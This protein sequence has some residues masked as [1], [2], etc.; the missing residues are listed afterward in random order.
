M[1]V[2]TYK[3]KVPDEQAKGEEKLP[4]IIEKIINREKRWEEPD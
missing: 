2:K 4:E 1:C 3:S